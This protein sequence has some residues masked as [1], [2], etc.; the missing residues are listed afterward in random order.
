VQRL[1]VALRLIAEES[2]CQFVFT[3]CIVVSALVGLI[4]LFTEEG[5]ATKLLSV[6]R[7]RPFATASCLQQN[8]APTLASAPC[9][10]IG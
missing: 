10:L 3:I 5:V 1:T 4:F 2:S 9:Y 7:V 6:P 8:F